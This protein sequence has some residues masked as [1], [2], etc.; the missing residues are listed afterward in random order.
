MPK[1]PSNRA[2]AALCVGAGVPEAVPVADVALAVALVVGA[3]GAS[4]PAG[5][6]VDDAAAAPTVTP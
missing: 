2:A 5:V 6:A 4:V 1:A 3:G